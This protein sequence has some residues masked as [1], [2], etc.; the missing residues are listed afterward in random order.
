MG[1]QRIC[2]L[3]LVAIIPAAG[4]CGSGTE[5]GKVVPFVT[6]VEPVV[7]LRADA[8][9]VVQYRGIAF[10]P[11]G[12][13]LAVAQRHGTVT[14]FDTRTWTPTAV[15]GPNRGRIEYLAFSRDGRLLAAASGFASRVWDVESRKEIATLDHD[16]ASVSWVGFSADDKAVLSTT[17]SS[18]ALR[19]LDIGS[20]IGTTLFKGKESKL[21]VPPGDGIQSASTADGK[22]VAL[23][24]SRTLILYD[25]PGRK[26]VASLFFEGGVWNVRHSPDGTRLA[27]AS[28]GTMALLDAKDLSRKAECQLG[29]CAYDHCFTPDG[30][31]VVVAA[32]SA[33]VEPGGVCVVE[34]ATGKLLASVACYP[35]YTVTVCVSPDG[36]LVA[37]LGNMED[38]VKLWSMDALLKAGVNR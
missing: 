20:G 16:P 14:L 36:K 3:V 21:V 9:S 24:I 25:L 17:G 6:L 12:K 34:A 31:M 26:E 18:G 30:T 4:A 38:S 5:P 29:W 7:T 13:A 15:L 10:S 1:D 37:T 22:A 2:R 32:G 11:D 28:Q 33:Y 23:G 35:R 27:V 8:L 19:S